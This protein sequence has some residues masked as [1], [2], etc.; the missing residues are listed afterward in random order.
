MGPRLDGLTAP[1][2]FAAD[3]LE[4]A[5]QLTLLGIDRDHQLVRCECRCDGR[6]DVLKLGVAVGMPGAREP[7]PGSCRRRRE[8]VTAPARYPSRPSSARFI[9]SL[10]LAS[11]SNCSKP[12]PSSSVSRVAVAE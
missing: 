9:S 10:R 5:D 7:P 4:I 11:L 8:I 3:G 12:K 1:G 2:Q 6:V